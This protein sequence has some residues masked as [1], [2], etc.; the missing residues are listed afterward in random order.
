MWHCLRHKGVAEKY[1]NIIK[2]MYLGSQTTVRTAAGNTEPFEVRVG[3]HQGS[4]LSPLLFSI[5]IDVLTEQVRRNAPWNILYADD[6][7]LL[8]E[9]KD[10]A[11][12]ELEKWREALEQRGLRVSRSKTEYL[13]IGEE[14]ARPAVRLGEEEIAEVR[15]FKYLGST[16]QSDGGCKR[17]VKKRTQA[18]WNSWRKVT[19]V[20]CDKRMPARLKGRVY[21]AV[22][23]PAMMYG[24]ETVP[25]TKR[26]EKEMEVAEMRML[27]WSL[28]WTREDKIRNE[29]IRRMTQVEQLSVKARERRLRWFGHVK[30]RDET[31][32]GK[33]VMKME[34]DGKRKRGRPKLRWVDVLNA[35][36]RDLE[37]EEDDALDRQVWACAIRYSN[38]ANRGTS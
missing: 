28:G 1:I 36:M 19:G 14:K 8:N 7:V 18:G 4:A 20:M 26:Q 32:V 17:E 9:T 13:C 5:V 16:V 34:V 21:T 37:L 24:L 22:I 2:D 33:R 30:R 27:R 35:D 15:E 25:L 29:K 11:E 10:E 38:P 23:R 6:V 31:Y 12:R 3:L